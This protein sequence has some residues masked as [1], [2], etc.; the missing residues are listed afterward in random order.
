MVTKTYLMLLLSF[1]AFLGLPNL[2]YAPP[3]IVQDT[4]FGWV[5][6]IETALKKR[7]YLVVQPNQI[8]KPADWIIIPLKTQPTSAP[9]PHSQLILESLHTITTTSQEL[10]KTHDLQ[11]LFGK[12]LPTP[13]PSLPP[14]EF[15]EAIKKLSGIS[16]QITYTHIQIGVHT[17]PIGS[18]LASQQAADGM[19]I[20]SEKGT[21]LAILES[22]NSTQ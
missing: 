16:R 11:N 2:L 9:F 21:L 5:A 7:V 3:P 4:Q 14:L 19:T 20:V 10:K 6:S 8:E 22:T 13:L 12:N 15:D 1:L 17:G 18:F